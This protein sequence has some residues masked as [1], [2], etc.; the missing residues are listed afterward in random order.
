ML[1]PL[2]IEGGRLLGEAGAITYAR[3]AASPS[4]F[5]VELN[6]Q[7][8]V[9]N[10]QKQ[11]R[12]FSRSDTA[13]RWLQEIGVKTVNEVDLSDWALAAKPEQVTSP[14]SRNAKQPRRG[15]SKVANKK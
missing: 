10:R 11:P 8:V 14:T 4:G 2:L 6:N 1:K 12:Y 15:T 5:T 3:V 7:F 13:F 9:A